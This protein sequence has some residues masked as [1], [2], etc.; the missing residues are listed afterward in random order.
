MIS[1][2]EKLSRTYYELRRLVNRIRDE[3]NY[4]ERGDNWRPT[5]YT[6]PTPNGI[7]NSIKSMIDQLKYYF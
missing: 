7:S 3:M 4:R 6:Q 1:R 2:Q 5:Y